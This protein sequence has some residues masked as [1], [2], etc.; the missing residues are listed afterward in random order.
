MSLSEEKKA[1]GVVA[2][3]AGNHALALSWQGKQLGISHGLSSGGGGGTATRHAVGQFNSM[4]F[5][6]DLSLFAQTLQGAQALLNTIQEFEE[7][8]ESM[9]LTPIYSVRH[10]HATQNGRGT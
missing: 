8:Q 4:G 9:V 5:V 10:F 2:A 1:K 3:S 6:D 7:V